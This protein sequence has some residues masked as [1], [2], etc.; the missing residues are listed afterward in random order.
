MKNILV[1]K[2]GSLGDIISATSVLSDIRYH[3]K[4]DNIFILTA[5]K[6]ENFFKESPL[7]NEVLI[8]NR[9]GIFKSAKLIKNIL[10]L[11]FDLIIDLQNTNRTSVYNFFFR[12]FSS[13][14]INGTGLFANI[15]YKN[16][17]INLPSVI[18]G[19]SNQVE[20]LGIKTQ[21][22]PFVKWLA[23]KAFDRSLIK[24]ERYFIINPGCSIN[25]PQ[26]RWPKEKY[27]KICT[28]LIT[29][30]ITP[31]LIGAY[32]DKESIDF[33]FNY[34]N[35]C[36]NLYNKSSLNTIFQLAE[37]AVGALS[38]DTGPAHL[39]AAAGCKLHL[40]LSS[41]SNI[42]TVI[43]KGQNITFTQKK[44]IDEISSKEIIKLLETNYNI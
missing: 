29:K 6:F 13:V 3:Y 22:K 19:L 21:R 20:K 2:H 17:N 30:K 40:V 15:R 43:P 28:F 34:E 8:D 25:N 1:I 11:K 36:L 10:K 26:K 7:I 23:N 14:D 33:I 38:N 4:N 24:N 16:P 32:D 9:S 31:I 18:D 37:N 5:N 41:F 39:I 27:A 35:S 12:L 44:N 42:K